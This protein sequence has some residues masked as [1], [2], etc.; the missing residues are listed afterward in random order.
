MITSN[1]VRQLLTAVKGTTFASIDTDT[2]VRPAAA[3]KLVSIRKLT[4]ANVQ[5]FNS[6]KDYE[7]FARAV[8]RSAGVAEFVQ[9]DNW[10]EHTDCWSVVRHPVKG[11]EYLYAVYNGA[12]STF[13]IDGVAATRA[14]VAALLTPSAAAR[15]MDDS[16][17]VYNKRND[18][19]HDV[20]PRVVA[21]ENVRRIRTAGVE[22][23]A[24]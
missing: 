21:L 8:K 2:E 5:L 1:Q 24:Q 6:I 22:L 10:F 14:E 15:L 17:V 9:S 19:E 13:T 16:G 20:I 7:I 12:K 4:T 18:V 3:H 11:T 23:R